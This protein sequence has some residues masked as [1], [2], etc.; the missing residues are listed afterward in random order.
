[1]NFLMLEVMDTN[2]LFMQIVPFALIIIA[3]YFILMAPQ[4]REQKKLTEMR[5]E[6]QIGDAV[7]TIGGIVGRV[8]SLKEDTVVVET[9]EDRTK[10]RFL[11]TAIQAVD[12]LEM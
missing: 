4:K 1:M 8:V 5:R 6:L 9:A 10:I 3:M 2:A 12:K 7:T 11:R